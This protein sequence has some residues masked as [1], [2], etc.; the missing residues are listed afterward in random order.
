MA[1]DTVKHNAKQPSVGSAKYRRVQL[2]DQVGRSNMRQQD[3]HFAPT[4]RHCN[5]AT[6]ASYAYFDQYG[7][8]IGA[9]GGHT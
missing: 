7:L 6:A 4:R 9:R 2:D 3:I 5:A 8:T 1:L